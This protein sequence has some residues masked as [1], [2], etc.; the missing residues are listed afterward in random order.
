MIRLRP[1][2]STIDFEQLNKINEPVITPE[3]METSLFLSLI[4]K[5]S[6]YQFPSVEEIPDEGEPDPIIEEFPTHKKRKFPGQR[7]QERK[8]GPN[9]EKGGRVSTIPR[10]GQ[11]TR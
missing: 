11:T 3:P 6:N 9:F 7:S 8:K 1:Y 10:T 5:S 4:A 2:I